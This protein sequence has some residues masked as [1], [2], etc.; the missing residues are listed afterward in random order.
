M[1]KKV[2]ENNKHF[3]QYLTD[4]YDCGLKFKTITESDTMAI[5]NNIKAKKILKSNYYESIYTT[6][7]TCDKSNDKH[8]RIS[9]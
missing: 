6:L 2:D 9:R 7:E 5:I 3:G 1:D 4:H 8:E